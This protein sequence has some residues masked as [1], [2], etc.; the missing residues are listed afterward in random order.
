MEN[1]IHASFDKYSPRMV[2][3]LRVFMHSAIKLDN[4]FKFMTIEI[5]YISSNR[6]LA[7]KNETY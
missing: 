4:Q 3:F 5:N 1:R 7:A 2:I 6:M